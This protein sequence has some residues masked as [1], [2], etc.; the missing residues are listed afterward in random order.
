LVLARI[1]F[2]RPVWLEAL[3]VLHQTG[4][5]S[6][7]ALA[8]K[9]KRDYKNVHH[10]LQVLE[11]VGLVMRS[12]D[13]RLTA[14]WK[15]SSQ[16]PRDHLAVS[17]N[18]VLGGDKRSCHLSGGVVAVRFIHSRARS[19]HRR[20]RTRLDYNRGDRSYSA[21]E[22]LSHTDAERCAPVPRR[23]FRG[24]GRNRC[25]LRQ[26]HSGACYAAARYR[27]EGRLCLP[28]PLLLQR[29]GSRQFQSPTELSR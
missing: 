23:W 1:R 28:P 29:R 18:R 12:A 26:W 6:V 15:R 27:L 20:V 9:M 24:R 11:R 19:P 7:W 14:P 25:S 16:C 21:S 10:D 17:G 5:V 4:R 22:T 8:S 2:I 3:K 13:G